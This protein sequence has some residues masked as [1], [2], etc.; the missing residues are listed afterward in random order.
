[1]VIDRERN[2][3]ATIKANDPQAGAKLTPQLPAFGP[4]RE[5]QTMRFNS[6]DVPHRDLR[7]R[8]L[9]DP[10]VERDQILSSFP[11]S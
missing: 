9:S 1:M 8:C 4:M 7:V 3:D 2:C 5:V 6:L 11:Q 10:V